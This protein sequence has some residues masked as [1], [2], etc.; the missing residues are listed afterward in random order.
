[1]QEK[2]ELKHF[3]FTQEHSK[4]LAPKGRK[5]GLIVDADLIQK[6]KNVK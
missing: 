6:W 4:L 1:L 2:A 3:D 5:V